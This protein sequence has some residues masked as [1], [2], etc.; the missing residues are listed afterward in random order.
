MGISMMNTRVLLKRH[1]DNV[2]KYGAV[3]SRMSAMIPST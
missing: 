3:N 1:S 2:K